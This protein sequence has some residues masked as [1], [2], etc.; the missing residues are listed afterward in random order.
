MLAMVAFVAST[1]TRGCTVACHPMTHRGM[2]RCR[3]R[4][5]TG[6][7]GYDTLMLGRARDEDCGQVTLEQH[8]PN[9]EGHETSRKR[10]R[11]AQ[12][13]SGRFNRGHLHSTV[14][15]SPLQSGYAARNCQ[16]I[17]YAAKGNRPSLCLNRPG[18]AGGSQL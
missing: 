4:G 12:S 3:L 14:P 1:L 11:V 15:G 13:G 8:Q 7:P 10:H 2:S 17:P 16:V 5:C 6:V 9:G 18:F